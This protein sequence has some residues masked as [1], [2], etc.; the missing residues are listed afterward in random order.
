MSEIKKFFKSRWE[1]GYIAEIDFSQLE[2]IALA[3]LS[4][5]QNL[6]NDILSGR[7]LHCARAAELAGIPEKEFVDRYK[8]G[9]LQAIELRRLAKAFSFQLQYGAGA[10]SMAHK[11]KVGKRL[12]QDFI[13]NY[14][15]R[16]PDVREWQDSVMRE[17]E[18]NRDW[19]GETRTANGYPA[20]MGLYYSI[21][22]RMYEFK[23]YDN[24]WRPGETSFSPT[25]VKNYP[26]QGFAADIVIVALGKI[27]RF[28]Q[29]SD[30]LA[31]DFIMINT[32]HDS[33]LFDVK[34]KE[35]LDYG[36]KKLVYIME[37]M[38]QYMK[39][40]YNIEPVVEK[41]KVDVEVGKN[42]MEIE[43]YAL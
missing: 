4:G 14:Y 21:T 29:N 2:I 27:Y 30:K 22:G 5:D 13:D 7:D 38:P 33:I 25:Q 15:T 6:I 41:L 10:N 16:Y 42:W 24:K 36:L 32:V 34:D 26:V 43:K 8:K 23:E 31:N 28:L 12:A 9:E 19:D 20:G 1:D 39:D 17:V 37:N 3:Q 18:S 11:N 35:T 40:I